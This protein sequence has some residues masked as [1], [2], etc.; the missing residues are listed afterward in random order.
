MN[1][2][3]LFMAAAL[4]LVITGC[5]N[6]DFAE[7]SP[8]LKDNLGKLIEAPLL[9]VAVETQDAATRGQYGDDAWE[10]APTTQA[11]APHVTGVDKIGLCWTGVNNSEDEDAIPGPAATTGDMVYTNMQFDHVGWLYTGETDA[12]LHCGALANGEFHD[13]NTALTP[14]ANYNGTAPINFEASVTGKTLNP[15]TGVFKSSNGT[16]YQ[17]EYIVYFPYNDAFWNAPVL[18]KQKRILDLNITAGAPA[19]GKQLVN[20]NAFN[21]GYV[22]NINGGKDAC[23][24]S[25]KLLTSGI[26]FDFRE[27]ST[28]TDIKEIVL[29][30]K[31]EK[32]FRTTQALSAQKIKENYATGIGTNVYME[33]AKNEASA[34]LVVRTND[35]TNFLKGSADAATVAAG[36]GA[37]SFYVPFLPG[38]INDLRILVVKKDGKTAMVD[39]ADNLTFKA[40]TFNPIKLEITAGGKLKYKATEIDFKDVNYAY[41]EDSFQDAFKKA[42]TAATAEA[43]DPRTVVMLDEITLTEDESVVSEYSTASTYPVIIASDPDY[44]DV[45]VKNVLTL[46]GNESAAIQYLFTNVTFDA[47]VVTNAQGCCNA[48]LVSLGLAH[49]ATAPK[50]VMTI[51]A[52]RLDLWGVITLDGD[53]KSVFEP[54]DEEGTLHSNRIPS[55][56][57]SEYATVTATANILNEGNMT[58]QKSTGAAT[59]GTL[60]LKGAAL[61]NAYNEANDYQATITI[62]GV[63]TTAKDAVI[64]MEKN[65]TVNATVSNEGKIYNKGN[66]DNNSAK[67]TFVNEEG[68][69]F[70]DFVGSTL[71]GYRIENKGE[72]I[73]EVNSLVRYNNAIDLQGIRPTTT[74]RFVTDIIGGAT[75]LGTYTLAPN[76][77]DG[78]YVPYDEEKLI[79]FES[80]FGATK[81]LTIKN[82][83]DADGNPVDTK[84][85]SLTIRSGKF[86]QAHEALHIVGNYEAREDAENTWLQEGL[87]EVTGDFILTKL[88]GNMKLGADKVMN[89]TGDIKIVGVTG[90][91]TFDAGSEVN[92]ANMSVATGNTVIFEK[93][94][95]TK[96]G[97]AG[98]AG[99]LTNNGSIEIV[100][101]VTGTDVAAKVW[102]NERQ[103]EGTYANNSYPQYY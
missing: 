58:L 86:T 30:S 73:S 60:I 43:A 78:I 93:N 17:G 71:S 21:V 85:G 57:I 19:N 32:A 7:K 6:D 101:T 20:D 33:S 14:R 89:V 42:R 45:P 13:W 102:C 84:I 49:C 47:D 90:N 18:A 69:E 29:W 100:N 15:S 56:V 25:T 53:V 41:D 87:K 94:N 39:L 65:G 10:W 40:K 99:V 12:K 37:N 2:K 3:Y 46:A 35:G 82:D 79:K 28:S 5:S 4:P 76:K 55:I 68:S 34:T 98:V 38:T 27:A 50:T 81:V 88:S 48:G 52:G 11:T 70:T 63:G 61:K 51:N 96:L 72:F 66:F 95:V 74:L 8:A 83:V 62:E 24:F 92:A 77:E 31:K 91:S 59:P 97:S 9:G 54:K 75:P 67:G 22:K 44:A 103:G 80:T 64:R 26:I 16:I 1:K 23:N 36:A